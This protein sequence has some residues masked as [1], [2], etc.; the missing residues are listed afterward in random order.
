M[1]R[2]THL[3][4]RTIA[5]SQRS[6]QQPVLDIYVPDRAPQRYQRGIRSSNFY[7]AAQLRCALQAH[8]TT[9]ALSTLASFG[10][11]LQLRS[12]ANQFWSR[13]SKLHLVCPMTNNNV[14]SA[15]FKSARHGP[16]NESGHFE[17]QTVSQLQQ[18]TLQTPQNTQK[19]ADCQQP[20]P[21]YTACGRSSTPCSLPALLG[22]AMG[23]S[24]RPQTPCHHFNKGKSQNQ[25]PLAAA[26]AVFSK[27][28]S[29]PRLG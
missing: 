19:P 26:V 3:R 6:L 16:L 1:S 13:L 28:P 7:A 10:V 27:K 24:G 12:S 4:C 17:G 18:Y 29:Q 11:P 2:M 20:S 5:C 25:R 9:A 14:G 23:S 8:C 15:A 21:P 22:P